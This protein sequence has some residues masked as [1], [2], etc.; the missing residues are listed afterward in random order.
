MAR[1]GLSV[2]PSCVCRLG[3]VTL[4]VSPSSGVVC[5]GFPASYPFCIS[6]S[7]FSFSLGKCHFCN[8]NSALKSRMGCAHEAALALGVLGSPSAGAEQTMNAGSTSQ[9]LGLANVSVSFGT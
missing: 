8:R 9:A 2:A 6:S 4:S 3:A 5:S 1:S 7:L